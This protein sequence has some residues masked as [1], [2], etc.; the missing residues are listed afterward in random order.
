MKTIKI[1]TL[2]FEN[3]Q[4]YGRFAQILNPV[5]PCIG[6]QPVLFYRDIIQLGSVS[7]L[8]FSNTVVFPTELL[9]NILEYHTATGEGFML[10]DGDAIICVGIA[11]ADGEIPIDELEAFYVPK[12]VMMYVNAGVWHYAP[13]PVNNKPINS[14]VIL[15]ERTYANDCIKKEISTEMQ[16][17]IEI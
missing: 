3:F 6:K 2:T 1:Q 7:P 15:P 14:L 12:G 16:L 9:V 17:M 13:Y 8:S 5:T 11:T 4:K 10:L